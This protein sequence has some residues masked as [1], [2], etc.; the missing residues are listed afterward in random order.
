[1]AIHIG[2]RIKLIAANFYRDGNKALAERLGMTEVNLYKIFLKENVN[3]EIIVK[4]SEIL[5]VPVSWFLDEGAEY[6]IKEYN[7][8]KQIG[9]PDY[10]LR[11]NNAKTLSDEEL[12]ISKLEKCEMEIFLLRAQLR[13][14]E[15]IIELLEKSNRNI[16]YEDK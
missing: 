7:R 1:M 9:Y 14:K 10:R 16:N 13:D 4:L 8:I 3:T 15:R 12:L 6:T 11:K 5:E 2:S